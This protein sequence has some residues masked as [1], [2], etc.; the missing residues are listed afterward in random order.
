MRVSP[1]A[2]QRHLLTYTHPSSRP[3]ALHAFAQIR[4]DTAYGT[5]MFELL[6]GRSKC[7]YE[8]GTLQRE[9]ARVSVLGGLNVQQ[10]IKQGDSTVY[11]LLIENR[12]GTDEP[13]AMQLG[14]DLATNNANMQLQLMGAPWIEPVPV[15]AHR[16]RDVGRHWSQQPAGFP[17][18]SETW[19]DAHRLL[20]LQCV[21]LLLG[22]LKSRVLASMIMPLLPS[23]QYKLRGP[24]ATQTKAV[25]TARCGPRYL[26]SAVDIVSTGTCDAGEG[27]LPG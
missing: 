16:Y 24:I 10:N 11:E 21:G 25:V 14:P 2:R 12:S 7:P 22:K 23:L 9:L 13:V 6:A 19:T 26:T 4:P 27:W 20:G 1:H 15:G 8:P 3:P 18:P 17:K 5:P